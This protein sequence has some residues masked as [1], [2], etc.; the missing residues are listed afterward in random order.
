MPNYFSNTSFR[1]SRIG[2]P[3]FLFLVLMSCCLYFDSIFFTSFSSN[4]QWISNGMMCLVFCILYSK[5]TARYKELMLYATAIG[6]VGECLLS[7]VCEMYTY[8]L[9][10]VPLYVPPGHAIVY[11]TVCYFCKNDFVQLYKVEIEQFFKIFIVVFST[12]FL[13]FKNDVFGFVMTLLTFWMLRNR[14]KERF[15]FIT[16]YMV[17]TGLELIGTY[18]QCWVWPKSAFGYFQLLSSANPPSGISFCYFSLDVGCLWLYKK[19]HN[20][21]WDR[22]K[23]IRK[24]QF[25]T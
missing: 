25:T 3:F 22:M 18:Y 8:R 5:A 12:V 19:R 10:N 20:I 13:L 21:A 16:M 6:V 15:F 11:I 23:V 7:L 14:N 2:N 9:Q 1:T 4:G 24:L 17:V